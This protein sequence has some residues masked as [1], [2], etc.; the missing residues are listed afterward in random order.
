VQ[1]VIS[2]FV[3]VMIAISA[4]RIAVSLTQRLSFALVHR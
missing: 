4:A 2:V 1:I 3:N